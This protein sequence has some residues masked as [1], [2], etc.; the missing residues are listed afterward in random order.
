M[1]A[2]PR[3]ADAY[4]NLGHLRAHQG[5]WDDAV[6]AYRQTLHVMPEHPQAHSNLGQIL[7]QQGKVAD[8]VAEFEA[9]LRVDP[10][11]LP[12]RLNLGSALMQRGDLVGAEEQYQQ[13]LALDPQLA[14]AHDSLG[15]AY[16]LSARPEKA[17]ESCQRAVTLAPQLAR[18]RFDVA[19]A[20]H[21]LGRVTE[22]RQWYDQALPMDPKW[23][24]GTNQAAWAMATQ[25]P[26]ASGN[27][28]LAVRLARQLCEA[29]PERADYL[30]TLG[31]ALGATGRFDE[32]V[33]ASRE[34][35]RLAVGD[36]PDRLKAMQ[37]RLHRF[38]LRQAYREDSGGAAKWPAS[39]TAAG[40]P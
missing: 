23:P 25:P 16:G 27:G 15:I 1:K 34:A 40:R 22:A 3:N 8:A 21:Q 31:A 29:V 14:M 5:R 33:R 18:Y 7:A 28:A 37:E 6:T 2:E 20:L 36:S 24:E 39:S 26:W 12:A 35:V 4:Y 38:E 11:N 17:L 13:A 9:A 30:D 19:H 32:A 10:A